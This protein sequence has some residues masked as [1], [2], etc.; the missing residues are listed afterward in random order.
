MESVASGET[1]SLRGKHPRELLGSHRRPPGPPSMPLLRPSIVT[2]ARVAVATL[3]APSPESKRAVRE[4][5]SPKERRAGA[6]FGREIGPEQPP[7]PPPRAMLFHAPLTSGTAQVDAGS[8]VRP[9]E[10]GKKGRRGGSGLAERDESDA[11]ALFQIPRAG[12]FF[13]TADSVVNDVTKEKVAGRGGSAVAALAAARAA[14]NGKTP[15]RPG[16]LLGTGSAA[17]FSPTE[18][19]R[20]PGMSRPAAMKSQVVARG[21]APS[22]RDLVAAWGSG[23]RG[24]ASSGGRE[25]SVFSAPNLL[26]TLPSV[27]ERPGDGV[28]RAGPARPAAASRST[29]ST[30]ISF[31]P[32]VFSASRRAPPGSG[33]SSVSTTA[34][35]RPVAARPGVGGVTAG[36]GVSHAD[37]VRARMAPTAPRESLRDAVAV[38]M[39]QSRAG[40]GETARM[41]KDDL[42]KMHA[43]FIRK[44]E[45]GFGSD[46]ITIRKKGVIGGKLGG[47]ITTTKTTVA[48]SSARKARTSSPVKRALVSAFKSPAGIKQAESD[49]HF[50]GARDLSTN[51]KQPRSSARAGKTR[52]NAYGNVGGGGKGRRKAPV[53]PPARFAPPPPPSSSTS[54]SR[55]KMSNAVFEPASRSKV[56]GDRLNRPFPSGSSGTGSRKYRVPV[57]AISARVGGA[58]AASA[59]SGS[60]KTGS[61]SVARR[62]VRG[63]LSVR[64]SPDH[65]V[66][67]LGWGL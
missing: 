6:R 12:M 49:A 19:K 15:F 55:T 10:K 33:T 14:N 32:P 25:K 28:D 62:G 5:N 7:A 48:L 42:K 67:S 52:A 44:I 61:A 35:S 53:K 46:T 13:A 17:A 1:R 26:K 34:S 2:D 18:K 58:F 47:G 21:S 65:G 41:A 38:S 45:S 22:S 4:L 40:A 16:S 54:F 20:I 11:A 66:K 37:R 9:G 39:G 36:S 8:L 57:S 51:F 29:V 63:P 43:E 23:G 50:R 64:Y 3:G 27:F 59:A 60:T 31:A 30:A 24:E 56:L